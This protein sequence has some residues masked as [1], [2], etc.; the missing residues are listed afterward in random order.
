M[1][2]HRKK[3][4]KGNNSI[5][6]AIYSKFNQVLEHKLCAKYHDTSINSSLNLLFIM[7]MPK[8]EKEHNSVKYLLNFT[9]T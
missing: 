2:T 9:K 4:E 7:S 8:S 3:S 5:I 6:D 1:V